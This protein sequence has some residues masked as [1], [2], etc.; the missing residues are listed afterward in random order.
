LLQ[1]GWILD[2]NWN[3]TTTETEAISGKE[4]NTKKNASA[5]ER[6]HSTKVFDP[7]FDL[8]LYFRLIVFTFLFSSCQ[9]LFSKQ[10]H[11]VLGLSS[12]FLGRGCGRC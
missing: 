3:H 4:N 2:F 9:N 7:T 12:A 11:P 6:A 5:R 1:S 10:N 8:L